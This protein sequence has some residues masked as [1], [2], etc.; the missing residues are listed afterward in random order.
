[1]DP[2]MLKIFTRCNSPR[3]KYV[4]DLI[5]FSILG[6]PYEIV[7]DRRRIGR[8]PVINYSG[9]KIDDAFRIS[10]SGLLGETGIKPFDIE[11][12]EW[13]NLPIFFRTETDA[14]F[15]FDIFSAIFYMVTRYEEYLPFKPDIHG[16][17]PAS[18]SLAFRNG[19]LKKPVVNLWIKELAAE[20]VIH[21]PELVFKKN[22]FKSF[23][24]FDVDEPFKYL[25]KDLF[26]NLGGMLLDFGKRNSSSAERYRTI[27]GKLKDPWNIF[28]YLIE[29]TE[30]S[31]SDILIFVPTGDRTEFDR[32][33]TWNNED[34]TELLAAIRSNA[35]IGLHPSYFS[36]DNIKKL[37]TEKARLESLMASEICSARYHYIRLK[38]PVSYSTLEEA[39]IREDY[40]MGFA[41]EPG[42]RAGIATPFYFYD[43]NKENKTNLMVY[44]FQVMDATLVQ[45][46]KMNP[47]DAQ[48]LIEDLI[49][50]TRLAGG[51]F[52]SV[53]HNNILAE[54]D[55]AMEWRAVFENTL[56]YQNR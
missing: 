30:N 2:W 50:E 33:P 54:G 29:K 49:D 43:L 6:V 56:K 34:Y 11:V 51:I 15:P 7:T 24:T 18:M 20:L 8:N 17:F 42:F 13:K 53:W 41:D 4:A 16:R 21:F 32:W 19:F 52:Q 47:G 27:K 45:Y 1:M 37:K 44:P 10:P 36:S 22:S 25:G 14:D 40:S 48:C 46:R 3:L 39:G 31:G 9:E 28:D 35:R 5:F 38:L 23:V 26:R 55:A 12:S